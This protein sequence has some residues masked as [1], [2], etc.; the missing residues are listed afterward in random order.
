MTDSPPTHAHLLDP[1]ERKRRADYRSATDRDAFTLGVVTT[2][3]VLAAHLH[4]PP[5]RV[6]IDRTCGDC[7]RPHGRPHVLGNPD[8]DFSVTHSGGCVAVAFATGRTIGVDVERRDRTVRAALP[9]AVLS[10]TERATLGGMPP[11]HQRPGFLRYWVR[12]EAVL[13]A[14]GHG[15]RVPMAD[16]TV[17]PPHEHPR[18]IRWVGRP[19]LPSQLDLVDLQ[20]DKTYVAS[21]A[22]IGGR[23]RTHEFDARAILASLAG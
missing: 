17:S 6:V 2:R 8:I 1:I 4:V 20:S 18:L 21:L 16:L 3:A 12:K 5:E 10:A 11:A 15:L 13:K 7:A 14:T 22:M 23:L 19:D 9:D